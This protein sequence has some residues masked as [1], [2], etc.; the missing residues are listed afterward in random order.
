MKLF[1][2]NKKFIKIYYL[3]HSSFAIDMKLNDI[4]HV[5]AEAHKLKHVFV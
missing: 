1:S 3:L 4:N 5:V 2:Y